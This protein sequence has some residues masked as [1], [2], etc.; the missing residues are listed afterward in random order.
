LED[1]ATYQQP[2]RAVAVNR[3][4]IGITE[5]LARA[6]AEW[7]QAATRLSEMKDRP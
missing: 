2:G 6:I 4:T 3:E 1:P 5:D 7:E